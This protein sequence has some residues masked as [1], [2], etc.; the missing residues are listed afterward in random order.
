MYKLTLTEQER[1]AFD[2]IGN[3]YSNGDDMSRVIAQY[4]TE[5]KEWD[6]KGTV[7]FDLAEHAAWEIKALAENDDESFPCFAESLTIKMLKFLG[8]IV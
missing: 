3:R 5:G 1:A 7:T 6:S 4:S 2:W 8:Q